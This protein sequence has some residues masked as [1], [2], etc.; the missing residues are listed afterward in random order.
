MCSTT[1]GPLCVVGEVWL[2]NEVRSTADGCPGR[3]ELPKNEAAKELQASVWWRDV[4]SEGVTTMPALSRSEHL[5]LD[6]CVWCVVEESKVDV[7]V[8]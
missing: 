2:D 1:S 8:C 7:G 3:A 5:S 4:K 6:R